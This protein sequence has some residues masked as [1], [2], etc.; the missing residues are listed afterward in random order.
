MLKNILNLEGTK[1]LNK[2]ELTTLKGGFHRQNG[3]GADSNAYCWDDRFGG[4]HPCKHDD[5]DDN[6]L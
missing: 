3:G 1:E 2:K 6:V 5:S 4:S